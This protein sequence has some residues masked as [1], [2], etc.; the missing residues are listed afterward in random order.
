MRAAPVLALSILGWG[1]GTDAPDEPDMVNCSTVTDDDEF[2][3][4]L[5][6]AGEQG[7]LTFVLMAGDPSPPIRGDN[8]WVIQVEANAVP[9]N[10]AAISVTPR[11]PAHG[12]GA[13]KAVTV[14][15]EVAAGQYRLSPVNLWMPGVWETTI[16]VTSAA[17]DDRVILRFCISS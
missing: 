13:G 10:N 7:M 12:H 1:C 14:S 8:S 3:I 16:N 17:G 6:K 15:A 5:T 11:M 2:V 9:I 4:G